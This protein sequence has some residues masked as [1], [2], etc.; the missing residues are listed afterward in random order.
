M[1]RPEPG[2]LHYQ[3]PANLVVGMLLVPASLGLL[4]VAMGLIAAFRFGAAISLQ[5]VVAVLVL[6]TQGAILLWVS[7]WF[8]P[9]GLKRVDELQRLL[10]GASR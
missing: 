3:R 2:H 4:L 1:G 9:S 7:W 8:G 5:Q 10:G 6:C